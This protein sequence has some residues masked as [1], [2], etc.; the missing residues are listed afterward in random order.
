MQMASFIKNY[1]LKDFTNQSY[2]PFYQL[3]IQNTKKHNRGSDQ[4][5]EVCHKHIKIN[6]KNIPV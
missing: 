1:I 6:N 4:L 2:Q 5:Y 3:L